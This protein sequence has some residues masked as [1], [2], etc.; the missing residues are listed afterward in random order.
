M[1]ILQTLPGVGSLP[2]KSV[3]VGRDPLTNTSRGVC[4]LEMN[5]TSDAMRLFNGLSEAGRLDIDGREGKFD[6]S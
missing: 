2:I 1:G 5:N 6:S 4:Y 3:R